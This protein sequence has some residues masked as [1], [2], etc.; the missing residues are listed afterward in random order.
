MAEE[1][2]PS[3]FVQRIRQLGEQRDP[4]DAERVKKLEE[5]LIQGRS[6]RLA[7]RAG[8][9]MSLFGST[10][11]LLKTERAR[12]ISPD[13]P[14]TPQS[15]HRSSVHTPQQVQQQAASTP[16]PAMSPPPPHEDAA[17]E[18]SLQ[19]LTSAPTHAA[20]DS[21][22]KKPATSAAALGRSG[23]LSWKQRPQSGSIRRPMSG[24]STFDRPAS[25]DASTP[26]SPERPASRAQIAASLGAKDP[27]Y[28]RQTADR[29]IGS[30]AY[31]RNEEDS[32]SDAGSMSGRRQLPGMSR[33]S[34]V[35]R[36][37]TTST[38]E[39]ALASPPTESTTSSRPTSRGASMR[40]STAMSNRFSA[41]TSVSGGDA[42]P[43]ATRSPLPT[44]DSHKFAPPSE[45]G[46]TAEGGD[47]AG[48]ARGPHMSPA[49][50]RIL[51]ERERP[52]SPTKGMGGFVLSASL[53]RSDSVS[54]RW[55]T[56]TPPTLSRQSSS[57]SNR[58]SAVAGF[59]T[60]S[61]M[62]RPTSLSREQSTEPLS[63]PQSSSSNVTMK[64]LGIDAAPKDEFVRPA[65]PNRHSRSKSVHSTFSNK[66]QNEDGDRPSSPSKRFNP[67]KSS[68]LENALN[69]P[70]S[71]KPMAPASPQQPAWMAELNRA[72]QQRGSVDLG[73][74]SPL[75]TPFG[76][77]LGSRPTPP[78][79]DVQ[80]RPIALR[81]TTLDSP[82]VDSPKLDSPKLDAL[83]L[84]SSK[85][86]PFAKDES[87]E[88]QSSPSLMPAVELKPSSSLKE[89]TTAPKSELE[90]PV[91]APKDKEAVPSPAPS[92]SVLSRFPPA[93][94]PKPDT[95]PKKDFR[96][97]L[98]SRQTPTTDAP[99]SQ[100][101]SE[102]ANV[103]GKLRKAET[104]NYVAPNILKANIVGGK[105]ALNVTGGPKPTIRRDEFRESLKEKRS[106][107]IE[108]V[109]EEGSVLKRSE[110][111]SKPT[112]IPEAI[113]VRGRLDRSK[114]ISKFPPP[115]KE[116][117]K[118]IVPEALARKKSLRGVE[119]PNITQKE[120]KPASP[121]PLFA[122]R[123][124]GK[125][126]K[127][128]DRFNPAL[129]GMLVRGPPPLAAEKSTSSAGDSSPTRPAQE[130]SSGPA[131]ELTHMTKGRARGPKR[132]TPAAKKSTPEPE[133]LP[134]KVNAT[135]VTVPLVKAR[136]ILPSSEPLKANGTPEEPRVASKPVTPAKP[137]QIS[138][139]FDKAST[140][141]LTKKPSLVDL[142]KR[143]SGTQS[144]PKQ[145]P[146]PEPIETTKTSSPSVPKKSE[147]IVSGAFNTSQQSPKTESIRSP[148]ITSIKSPKPASPLPSPSEI[149]APNAEVSP[150]KDET[151][152]QKSGFSSVKNAT[153]LWGR[154]SASSSPVPLRTK[155]PIKLPTQADEKA[156]MKD[157]GLVRS[158]EPEPE[159]KPES[160]PRPDSFSSKP[161]PPAP[162]QPKAK[163]A[164]LG[165]SLGGFGGFGSSA[166]RSRESSPRLPK[167]L[168][169]SPPRSAD[170]PQPD[171][172]KAATPPAAPKHD[173]IFAEFFDEAPM[174]E[175]QLP[176]SIDA[177]QVLHSPPFDLGPAGKV[178]TQRQ[179][180]QE[181][182]GDGK[183]LSI[184]AHEQHVLFQE[185]M[186]ICTHVYSDSKGAKNND[187][188]LWAGNSVAESNIED[189]QLFARNHAK[190]NQAR[191][192][193]VRQGNEPPN[194]FDALG[195]IVITRRG[196]KPASKQFM[197]CGRRHL[198]HLAFDEVDFELKS[199]C[200]AF[201][202]LISTETGKVFLW[203]GRGCSAEEL[204]GARL[205]GMDLAPTGDFQEI[206]EGSEPSQLI[207]VFPP[208]LTKGPAIPRSADHWRYK[209]TSD[210]YRARLYRIDQQQEA[211][212]GWGQ[213]LQVGSFFANLRRSSF[214]QSL[215]PTSTGA[216][217]EH[218]PQT[219]MTPKSPLPSGVTT[220]VVE[221]MP[222]CQRDLEP[223]Y[224]YV[225]DAFFEMY[226]IVGALARTQA[227]AFSTALMFAQEY[228]ILAVSEE[229]RPFMPVTTIVLE[230]VPRDMKAV[231]RHWNDA[232]IPT[233]ELMSGSLK[234]GKSLRI[235]GLE[236][237]IQ[238]TRR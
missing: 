166:S 141:E 179:Q 168:P 202:Y 143:A 226:I 182:I 167:D 41:A 3:E 85:F 60:L 138:A 186:Y 54:K 36:E 102:L 94:K 103:F 61:K 13:K 109:Q 116:E 231:F 132:R 106:S 127:L 10:D 206:D 208:N 201:V 189:A 40:G 139:K 43:A 180:I 59:G 25:R 53:K 18:A 220:K 121:A 219:P 236:K 71:P 176:E 117:E 211:S 11:V 73:K 33:D 97:G 133:K 19:R 234:R 210:R 125:P 147:R 228:G 142:D 26:S 146:R 129:A 93:V 162:L 45:P 77:K 178:R 130:E 137:R 35:S 87:K 5:D 165:F 115:L 89:E 224:I 65:L 156:A 140:A 216:H 47:D 160:S 192:L 194:F 205:M 197:L 203:K 22:P 32:A 187:V 82:K 17:R 15:L 39:P 34:T 55:S 70:E 64:G 75:G 198:G 6:E 24:A 79:K 99:K 159:S 163:P 37:S 104:K 14:T 114:S 108:K 204:S 90:K 56:Q 88:S 119:R 67:T 175:G 111:I 164:G 30:A 171:T 20:D 126:N 213:S 232:L 151:S 48:A 190:Q 214:A 145:S 158:P 72:K 148:S 196:T 221:I 123:D 237:A 9:C 225:L 128:A 238:A 50:G 157:A 144:I 23:T 122:K 83:K 78:I 31:R 135:V 84:D 68:W 172:P 174:T 80:L 193:I 91:E 223:E 173:G 185:S 120:E 52:V 217:A 153:A 49:Q 58:G 107:M 195:G 230:G 69:K 150:T 62:E 207:D 95:P 4:Q 16:T 149:P 235:V 155:S 42:D 118:K 81:K 154:Q 51:P 229:D 136:H 161:L 66:D 209:A 86:D 100:A 170:K 101:Q 46:A 184:P 12:S 105:N 38:K 28:F 2:D 218:G 169:M 74:G 113:A 152:P 181:I 191:L 63:R 112:V 7:R 131:P 29:G 98:K 183:M 199:F 110:S 188:Y 134:E 233:A 76:E 227:P 222:F 215:S 177:V 27:A 92:K 200:S 44:L 21:E 212:G 1:M 8:G 124:N 57:L 96:A